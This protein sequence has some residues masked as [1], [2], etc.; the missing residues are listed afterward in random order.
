MDNVVKKL[1]EI[2]KDPGT[3][4]QIMDTAASLGLSDQLPD[5]VSQEM[6]QKMIKHVSNVI[7]QTETK[8]NKQQTLIRA[9]LPYLSPGR[10]AR[11]ERAMQLSQISRLAGAAIRSGT[12]MH[13]T[14]RE[15]DVHV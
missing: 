10:Q 15:G 9:L 4:K 3:I 2:M 1:E 6:P 7:Q 13:P 5:L 11:L 12:A 8:E 14:V